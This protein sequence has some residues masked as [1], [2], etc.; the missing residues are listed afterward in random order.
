MIRRAIAAALLAGLAS[1][2]LADRFASPTYDQAA[3]LANGK[4]Q[5]DAAYDGGA[6]R[7]AVASPVTPAAYAASAQTVLTPKRPVFSPQ[8]VPAPT[9]EATGSL[10]SVHN[11]LYGTRETAP[12]N[13]T[14]RPLRAASGALAGV[15]VGL[16]IGFAMTKMLD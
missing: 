12:S 7:D 11:V 13:E 5:A 8:E 2:A 14:N 10:F 4:T 15:A 3:G 16:G 9:A 6:L 1:P